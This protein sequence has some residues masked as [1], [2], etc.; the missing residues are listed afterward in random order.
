MTDGRIERKVEIVNPLGF[1][2]RPAAEFVRLAGSFQCELWLEKDGVEVNAKSIMGV[3]MLAAEMG[4]Q[5]VIRGNGDDAGGAGGIDPLAKGRI[6]RATR[7][8]GNRFRWIGSIRHSAFRAFLAGA[9]S[10]FSSG[11]SSSASSS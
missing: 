8:T 11:T 6:G 5:L 10:S 4:S 7:R 1:H 9:P 2:A 3:L